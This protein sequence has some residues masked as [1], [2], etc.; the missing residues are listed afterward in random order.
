M[1]AGVAGSGVAV[2]VSAGAAWA[3]SA[4]AGKAGH[5]APLVRTL[6]DNAGASG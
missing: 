2:S 3:V 6:D 1:A 4:C 5:S